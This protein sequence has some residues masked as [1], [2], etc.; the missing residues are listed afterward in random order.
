MPKIEVEVTKEE[1]ED[2]KEY[3]KENPKEMKTVWKAVWNS[4]GDVC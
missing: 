1:L 2:L 3:Q 4:Y